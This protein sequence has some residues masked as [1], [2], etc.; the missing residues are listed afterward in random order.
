MD[1]KS[2]W[3]EFDFTCSGG[4]GCVIVKRIAGAVVILDSKN[5]YQPGLVFSRKEYAAFRR[6]VKGHGLRYGTLARLV[7]ATAQ[8]LVAGLAGLFR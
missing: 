5:P 4:G 6:R 1:T 8:G 2:T 7:R 3:P